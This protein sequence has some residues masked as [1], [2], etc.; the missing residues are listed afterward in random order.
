[1][2]FFLIHSLADRAAFR[3]DWRVVVMQGRDG[4]ITSDHPRLAWAKGF[5]VE[6]RQVPL[7][8]WAEFESESQ[9]RKLPPYVYNATVYAQLAEP[10][11]SDAVLFIDADTVV[12]RPLDAVVDQVLAANCL[13]AKSAWQPPPIDI[14]AII[15]HRGLAYDGPPVEYSG[16]GW[17]FVEPR[18]G[19]PYVNGGF[20][21]CSREMAN[22]LQSDMRDDFRFVARHYPGHYIWQVAQCLTMIRQ[23]IPLKCLD[24]RFNFGIGPDAPPLLGGDAGA[25]LQ[26]AVNEQAADIRVLHYCTKTP[27]FQRDLVMSSD[28]ALDAFLTAENDMDVGAETLR[29]AFL[30]YRRAWL[31]GPPQASV[32]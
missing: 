17:S 1:M 22:R 25:A 5:P 26:R 21:L 28:A 4:T 29:A 9:R 27:H 32:I 20:V 19:P 3:G 2:L 15:Q 16:Y 31:A 8:L 10:F 24:E 12:T 11:T 30:P 7:P 23:A 6:F 18:F 14:D 13:A